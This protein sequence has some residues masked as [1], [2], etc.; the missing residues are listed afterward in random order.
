M[1][2]KCIE[3]ILPIT[4]KNEN[5]NCVLYFVT[6]FYKAPITFVAKK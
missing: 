3:T 4:V 5:K 1:N 2:T 6:D